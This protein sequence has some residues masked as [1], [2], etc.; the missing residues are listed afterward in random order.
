M[1]CSDSCILS[2]RRCIRDYGFAEFV[3]P[4][5]FWAALVAMNDHSIYDH[6]VQ[7]EGLFL[8]VVGILEC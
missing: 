2:V 7:D 3:D 8:G 6:I 4:N 1:P 5:L